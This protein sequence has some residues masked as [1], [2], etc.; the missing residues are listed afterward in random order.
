[1]NSR[2]DEGNSVHVSPSRLTSYSTNAGRSWS[3]GT[4]ATVGDYT[5][6]AGD[7]SVVMLCVFILCCA[8]RVLHKQLHKRVR[9]C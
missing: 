8:W 2:F 7:R 5:S 9:V 3:K 1:M 4:A 6:Y